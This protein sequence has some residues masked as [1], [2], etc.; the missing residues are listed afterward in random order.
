[1]T[2]KVGVRKSRVGKT[3]GPRPLDYPLDI[4]EPR[5][6]LRQTERVCRRPSKIDE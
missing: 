5:S 2:G 3:I 1:M 4:R 6:K